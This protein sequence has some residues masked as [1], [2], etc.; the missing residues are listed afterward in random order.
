MTHQHFLFLSQYCH[1]YRARHLFC[2]KLKY[3]P[4]QPSPSLPN[5]G[6]RIQKMLVRS[7]STDMGDWIDDVE[8]S[9]H[10]EHTISDAVYLAHA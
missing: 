1:P 3:H 7:L 5:W 10:F 2:S 9:P 6:A 4:E 8:S